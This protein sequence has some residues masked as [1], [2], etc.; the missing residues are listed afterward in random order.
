MVHFKERPR[1]R[2]AV[3]HLLEELDCDLNELLH[4]PRVALSTGL[5]KQVRKMLQEEKEL[6]NY[7]GKGQILQGNEKME[8]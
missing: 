7:E 3:T 8:E 4:H 1:C 5:K 6:K 2:K